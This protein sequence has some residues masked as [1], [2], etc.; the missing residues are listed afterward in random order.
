MT[1]D[2]SLIFSTKVDS[3]GF[4]Q[5][6]RNLPSALNGVKSALIKVSA[7]VGVAFSVASISKFGKEAISLASDL[8]EVQNVVDTAFGSMTY[9]MEDF[10]K[11]SIEKFGMSEL[12]AKRF[13]STYMAMGKGMGL[14]SKTAAD[15]ALGATA[16][17]GD[18]ASFYNKSFAEVDTMMKSIWTGETESLKQIGVVMTQTNLQAYALSQ[19]I[20][21]NIADF[22]Q[23]TQTLLRY[24]YVMQQTALSQGDFA[25]TSDSW[26]N[27]TRIL[28]E[29][30]NILKASIGTGLIQVL[31]PAMKALNKLLTL[32]IRISEAFRQ[33]SAELFGKQVLPEKAPVQQATDGISG[34]A[35][36]EK[37]LATQ[38]EK[39]NKAAKR[40][41]ASFDELNRLG[42]N[43]PDSSIA[44]TNL[45]G[46]GGGLSGS[47]GTVDLNTEPAERKAENLSK[48]VKKLREM[49]EPLKKISFENLVKAFDRLEESAGRL[50][51][52]IWEGLEWAYYKILVP[53]AKWTIE[54]LL[55]AFLNLLS[56]ALDVLN[57]VIEL[58]R[59]L[60]EWLWD[61]FLQPI[62]EWT[63]GLIVDII[64]G[65]ADALTR[66][67]DWIDKHQKG[68]RIFGTI[69]LSIAGAF[70]TVAAVVAVVGTVLGLLAS[71]GGI[72]AAAMAGLHAITGAVGGAF[73]W[74]AANPAVLIIA[75]IGAII[76]IIVLL[77]THWDEV[78]ESA[79]KTWAAIQTIWDKAYLWAS[80]KSGALKAVM[81]GIKN[82]FGIIVN[83][84]KNSIANLKTIFH[85]IA[86]FIKGVFTGDWKR[87]W[88]GVKT[89]FSGIVDQ[90]KNKFDT[91]KAHFKNVVNSLITL[92]ENGVNF[93]IRKINTLHW[94]IP[95]WVPGIG[96]GKFGFNFSEVRIPRLAQGAVIPANR[97]FLA[98][99]GDQKNGRNLE[100]P[101]GLIREIFRE[102]SSNNGI[103]KIEIYLTNKMFSEAF[104]RYHNG[105]VKRTGISPLK[106]KGV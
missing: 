88:E 7:A 57:S 2:G 85:G 42:S 51:K 46:I 26:A 78:K 90:I 52:N 41:L 16:R 54:D 75:A 11:T 83:Y 6:V 27:Q 38:T 80:E 29:R 100:A 33:V 106:M 64:N 50:G 58:F 49:L 31:T 18:I 102:E 4:N 63:G 15:M 39:A 53:L 97:E 44:G 1:Y 105:V 22:D 82:H 24:G 43:Q 71:K 76:A 56:G 60:G 91:I 32:L 40:S 48:T 96:G 65:I 95:E 12:A 34:L 74:L 93:M 9:M 47:L 86:E 5:G 68:L 72:A 8:Q 77:V 99:L 45:G 37:D 28:T 21:G 62:A 20:R 94:D 104:I 87:A 66:L 25:K 19:G 92:L 61:N 81:D 35:D 3:N 14:N 10:A 13:A 69:L 23:Q 73:A 55:P 89:I 101:E 79:K 59:P 30:F 103:D 70:G 98:V 84:F 67:S 36:A 17:I